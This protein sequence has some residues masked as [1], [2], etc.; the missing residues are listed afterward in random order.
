MATRTLDSYSSPS[1]RRLQHVD[2][3]LLVSTLL[4]AGIGVVI[5]YTTTRTKLSLAGLDPHSY[6]KHQALFVVLGVLTMLLVAAVDYHR[7]EELGLVGY[8]LIMVA[9]VAVMS[10]LGKSALGSQRWFSLGAF[11]LQPSSFAILALILAAAT[12]LSRMGPD[13]N[14]RKLVVVLVMVG[15]PMG[16]VA[17]QPDL[18]TA[19]TIG[20][21]LAMMLVIAGVRGRYLAACLVLVVVASFGAAH[22]GLL[23]Q[24]Q[25]DRITAFIQ[26]NSGK[27]NLAGYNLEQSQI[28]IGDGGLTGKGLGNGPQTKLQY[29][30]E[31]QTDF[32]FTSVGEQLGFAGAA[33]L[34][35]LFGI[36]VWRTWRQSRLAYDN[37]GRLICAGVLGYIAFSVFQNVGMTM[38]I[39]PITGIPLP[40]VSYGGS[41]TIATFAAV[42]L[43][44]NVGMRRYR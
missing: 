7:F 14:A 2:L 28:A 12:V 23:R 26:Q 8:A 36:I 17:I 30:P 32:I 39:M 43:V 33:T 38:G 25:K 22:G 34:L 31:Q 41:S 3:L 5:V 20:T 11:Q 37:L 42:G 24:Y 27:S 6:L 21:S 44:L 15:L 35:V 10:P 4:V 29:V 13:I 40:M 18:G 16:L 1:M 19:I 9:L